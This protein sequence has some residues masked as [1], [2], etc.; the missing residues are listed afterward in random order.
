MENR[1]SPFFNVSQIKRNRG[2]KT[3][4]FSLLW[5]GFMAFLFFFD[6]GLKFLRFISLKRA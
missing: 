2:F 3:F 4:Y 6:S 1:E 5:S